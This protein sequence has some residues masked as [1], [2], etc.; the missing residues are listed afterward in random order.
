MMLT[1]CGACAMGAMS[2]LTLHSVVAA[3]LRLNGVIASKSGAL[4][5]GRSATTRGVIFKRRGV[6]LNLTPTGSNLGEQFFGFAELSEILTIWHHFADVSKMIIFFNGTIWRMKSIKEYI[7][8]IEKAL[9]SAGRYSKGVNMQ[10]YSLASAMRNL[11]LANSEIDTLDV[12]TVLE[13]TRYGQK[14]APHPVFKIAKEAQDQITRQMKALGLTVEELTGTDEADPLIELTKKVK[15]AGSRRK[16][17][18]K[19]V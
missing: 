12:T 9:K 17:V 15:T 14:L 19:R 3:R 8:D 7:T 4:L 6:P 10:I 5:S 13:E 16:V 2:R 11:D 1:I 18:I